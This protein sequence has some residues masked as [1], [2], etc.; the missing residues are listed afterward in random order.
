MGARGEFW[1]EKGP[2]EAQEGKGCG[3][4]WQGG[5]GKGSRRV[6]EGKER[7]GWRRGEVRGEERGREEEGWGRRAVP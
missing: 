1:K 3:E 4:G 7:G 2:E 6:G 5:E